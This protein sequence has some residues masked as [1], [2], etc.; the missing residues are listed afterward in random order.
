MVIFPAID[1]MDGKAVRLFKGDYATAKVYEADCV[2]AAAR[3]AAAGTTHIHIVDLDGAKRGVAQNSGTVAEIIAATKLF[4]Q[5][6]GGIRDIARIEKYLQA[7]ASRVILGTVAVRDYKFT[8]EMIKRYGKNIAVGVD[9]IDGK[10]AVDGWREVADITAS[11]LCARLLDAGLQNIIYTDISR[12]GTLCGAN[13]K[14]YAK[15]ADI[16]GTAAN[17]TASGGISSVEDIRSLRDIGIYGAILGKALYENKLSLDTAIA[18][19]EG[20]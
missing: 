15:L 3:F 4:A 10:V 8:A 20:N 2:T 17:I 11:D 12:D 7:G 9:A 6:G 1:I 14:A 19:A 13:I 5:V 16:V 18:V